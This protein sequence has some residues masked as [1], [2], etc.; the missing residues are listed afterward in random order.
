MPG[1]YSEQELT[2]MDAAAFAAAK[3][4]GWRKPV[5]QRPDDQQNLSSAAPAASSGNVWAANRAAMR[6]GEDFVTPSGQKCRM[7]DLT[8]E[9]LLPLGIL[10]RVTRLEGIANQLIEQAEGMPPAPEHMPSREDLEILLETLNLLVPVAVLE[11]K[12]YPDDAED[13]PADAI[14]VSDIDLMDR[15]AI[16]ERS[17]RKIRALDRFRHA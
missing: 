6:S 2:E 5:A 16:M 9:L 17:L 8:P 4:R 11:P 15:L 14:R 7:R 10:D 3:E 12:V 13:A 1:E